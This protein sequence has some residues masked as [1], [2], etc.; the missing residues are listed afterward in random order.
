MAHFWI[1]I[2]VYLSICYICSGYAREE[3][4]K[5]NLNAELGLDPQSFDDGASYIAHLPNISDSIGCQ[6]ACCRRGDCQLAILGTP[7]DGTAECF[8]VSCVNDG[9][10]V[11]VLRPSSQFQVFRKMLVS[12]AQPTEGYARLHTCTE[13]CTSPQLV[14]PCKAAHL[15]FYYDINTR[16][17]K[18]FIYGGCQG[19]SNNFVSQEECESTCGGVI[20]KD[21]P[22]PKKSVDIKPKDPADHCL[23]PS[24]PG[25]C[26]AA[27]PMFYYDS[28]TR[29]CRQFIYGGCGGNANRFTS[30]EYCMKTCQGQEGHFQ[31]R[32]STRDRWTPAFFL[33]AT[34][35]VISALLLAGLISMSV[36]KFKLTHLSPLDDKEDL[37]PEEELPSYMDTA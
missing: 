34:V 10:D 20:A 8:L 35:A 31:E 6:S 25:R 23:I 33:V 26:R 7:A 3:A 28:K 5:W 1:T 36:R 9:K 12:P 22:N 37:L 17:C 29:S 27:F 13:C 24:D 19:N 32:G 4:C 18:S 2:G 14:G 11:C 30:E 15:R 21:I 16:S